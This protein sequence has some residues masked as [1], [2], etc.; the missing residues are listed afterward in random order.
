VAAL[1]PVA[2]AAAD[3]AAVAT[4]A[5]RSLVADTGPGASAEA[6]LLDDPDRP[7]G[8]LLAL[9]LRFGREVLAGATMAMEV[10]LD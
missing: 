9:R 2:A 6:A 10:G 3:P 5:L 4:A 7:G 8:Q 1:V